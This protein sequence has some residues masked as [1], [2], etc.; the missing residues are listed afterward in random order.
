MAPHRLGPTLRSP[1]RRTRFTPLGGTL[2]PEFPVFGLSDRFAGFRWLMLWQR[3]DGLHSG[4][5]TEV[6]L[7]HGHPDQGRFVVV[8]TVLKQPERQLGPFGGRGSVGLEHVA[9]GVILNAVSL[10]AGHD[11]ERARPMFDQE[12]R[13]IQRTEDG[14][15]VLTDWGSEPVLID[16]VPH[17]G[18][19][20][21]VAWSQAIVIDLPTLVLGAWGPTESPETAWEFADVSAR[22][23]D[24]LA[25]RD[26]SADALI[27]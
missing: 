5:V 24:Y 17:Q 10:A 23:G 4:N 3:A 14:G 26:A 2:P 22:L 25:G 20:R 12:Q 9:S 21:R 18:R 1:Q 16:G 27:R 8:Q 15:A 13:L 11:S 6:W 7:A 19:V